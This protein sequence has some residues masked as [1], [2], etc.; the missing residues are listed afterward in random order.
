MARLQPNSGDQTVSM[1]LS[2]AAR[3]SAGMES[4]RSDR[5]GTYDVYAQPTFPG[6]PVLFRPQSVFRAGSTTE[7]ACSA[8]KIA[9]WRDRGRSKWHMAHQ[10]AAERPVLS[11]L[12]PASIA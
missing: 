11:G 5:F 12:A 2:M 7:I 10:M 6:Y 3:V 4:N 1:E 8:A 9:C